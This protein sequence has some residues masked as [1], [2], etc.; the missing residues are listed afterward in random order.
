[1]LL[2]T[3]KLLKHYTQ[4][5]HEFCDY[6]KGS[7]ENPTAN[8]PKELFV[9]KDNYTHADAPIACARMQ[10]KLPE[11]HTQ[12]DKQALRNFAFENKLFIF[13]QA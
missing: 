6:I 8:K 11:V 7:T 2:Q 13:P 10:G 9:L 3:N 4:S 1:M 5:Y 12:A